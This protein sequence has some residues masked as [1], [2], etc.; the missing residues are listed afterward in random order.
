MLDGVTP[1]GRHHCRLMETKYLCRRKQRSLDSGTYLKLR[2][3]ASEWKH[4]FYWDMISLGHD[5]GVVVPP[6]G[7]GITS[8]LLCS[9]LQKIFIIHGALLKYH[10]SKEK[11]KYSQFYRTIN[12]YPNHK[13]AFQVITASLFCY[14]ARWMTEMMQSHHLDTIIPPASKTD[15]TKCDRY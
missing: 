10:E 15:N 3:L 12:A 6:N 9:W 14:H 13:K 1:K 11:M 4:L 7:R 2:S 8:I 5:Y